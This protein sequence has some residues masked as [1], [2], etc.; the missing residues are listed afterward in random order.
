MARELVHFD[1]R[2]L[3]VSGVLGFPEHGEAATV[4]VTAHAHAG[5]ISLLIQA[6]GL[7][8]ALHLPWEEAAAL[9]DGMIAI[10]ADRP[11]DATAMVV[12]DTPPALSVDG[13]QGDG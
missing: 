8:R 12:P 1:A 2:P 4:S 10:L 13:E 7:R 11:I 3:A 6:P 9:T 5:G